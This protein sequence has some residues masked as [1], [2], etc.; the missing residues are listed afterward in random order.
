MIKYALICDQAH[1]FESWF[2]T[3]ASFEEQAKRGFVSCPVCNSIKVERAIMAPHVARTDRSKPMIEAPPPSAAPAVAAAAPEVAPVALMG[4]KEIALRQM[5]AELHRQ[6]AENAEHVGKRFAEEALKIHHGESDSRAI[7]GE[8]SL[9][10][11]RMLH[12]EGV[13]F[14][15]LPRLPDTGH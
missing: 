4:E 2:A 9:E 6:V 3:S 10:D 14:L 1:D 5:L 13:E 11:A 15:P 8:A 12:E 7:Y